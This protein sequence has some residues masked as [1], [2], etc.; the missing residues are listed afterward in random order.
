MHLCPKGWNE[1]VSMFR[2]YSVSDAVYL[3][4]HIREDDRKEVEAAGTTVMDALVHGGL[5]RGVAY[6]G[7]GPSGHPACV[8]GVNK[9]TR[10]TGLVWLLGTPEIEKI[11]VTF[12]RKSMQV[13]D[14]LYEVTCT[15][16]L[17]N[18]TWEGNPVHH[19]WL[20]WLGF[21]F[22]DDVQIEQETF[23]TFARLRGK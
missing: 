15:R 10:D 8:F 6:T 20:K 16:L 13:L 18:H 21:T 5:C 12:L 2:P 9:V 19:K 4:E 23:H 22:L 1:G 7:V 17:Y 14:R 11:P 3:S